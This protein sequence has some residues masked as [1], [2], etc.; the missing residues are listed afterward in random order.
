M[1]N[2]TLIYK[3]DA[4]ILLD[5]LED[6]IAEEEGW[7]E[8]C[9]GVFQA[10]IIIQKMHSL[11]AELTRHGKWIHAWTFMPLPK[12]TIWASC[13]LCEADYR[14]PEINANYCPNCGAKMDL[15]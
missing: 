6:Q 8:K 10:N 3:E 1:D 7:Q 13:S 12:G 4:L 9:D 15:E 14:G 5:N 11:D 2:K